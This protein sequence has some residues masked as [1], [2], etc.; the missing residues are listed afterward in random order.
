M[1]GNRTT[2]E[3]DITNILVQDFKKRFHQDSP[4]HANNIRNFIS[5]IEPVI[6][7]ND[8]NM[9][10]QQVT[11]EEILKAIHSIGALKAPGPD[12]LHAF[13]YQK[14]WDE[15][16]K[17][18]IPMIKRRSGRNSVMAVKL[19][20]EKAYDLLDWSYIQACLANYGF[21]P[22]W[23][24]LVMHCINSVSFSVLINGSAKGWFQPTRGIEQCDPLSPYIF[25]LAM[26]PLVRNLNLL[27]SNSK[28]QV[29]LLSSP[30]G[31]RILNLMFADDCLIFAKASK[32]AALNINRVLDAFAAASGQKINYHKSSLFFS[33]K[34][35]SSTKTAIVNVLNIQQKRIGKYL[36]IHNVVFWKDPINAKELLQRMSN[37]LSGW[38]QNTL[39]RAGK[40]TLIKA[41]I[42]GM[43]NHKSCF[44]CPKKLTDEIDKQGRNFLW[45]AEMKTT[46]IAW[47]EVC[48]PKM[49]GGLGVRPSAFFNKAAIG[50]LAWK[51][52]TN[53]DKW[54]VQVVSKKYLKRDGRWDK[55]KLDSV[56]DDEVV[57]EILS[58]PIPTNHA[59]DEFIWGPAPH[60]KFTV[61]S[62]TWMQ[63]QDIWKTRNE[64]IFR[65]K[66]PNT[67]AT[68]ATINCHLS[69]V[70][71]PL[72]DDIS[73]TPRNVMNI[74][75][76]SPS[77][78]RVKI[79]FDGSA[80]SNSGAGGFIIRTETDKS[81]VAAFFNSD[82]TTVSVAEALALHN[83]L[84][85]AMDRGFFKIEV[86]GSW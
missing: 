12:G 25:I 75:W 10:L 55:T 63:L 23:I 64:V 42:A 8:N 68:A 19:D 40:I 22:D 57:K 47:K 86:E 56:F 70:S 7:Q 9:L 52:I 38:K 36:G 3:D 46:T 48:K 53:K 37:R 39:S 71:S 27:A 73:M 61:K 59:E 85:Y 77:H 28:N 15:V 54:W 16:K 76:Q 24:T 62:A 58:V 14:C 2:N 84:V 51:L 50:K 43:P 5:V 41:N 33:D 34:I 44:N 69:N 29:G 82:T 6:N 65:G 72:T 66:T 32:K 74:R 78:D 31:F 4:P 45:G 30:L 83:S 20:L 17:T 81:V 18:V 35:N 67:N 21:H 26:E 79:N 13:F 80:W 60:G 1:E 11:D 49:L